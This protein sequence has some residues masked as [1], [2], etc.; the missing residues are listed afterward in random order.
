MEPSYCREHEVCVL[1]V[2]IAHA[3]ATFTAASLRGF[4]QKPLRVTTFTL[5]SMK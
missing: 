2:V 3:F 1:E 4:L 5:V